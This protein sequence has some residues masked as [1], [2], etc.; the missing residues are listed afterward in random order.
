MIGI[1][2]RKRSLP[3]DIY[4]MI[5]E[6][7]EGNEADSQGSRDVKLNIKALG[8]HISDLLKFSYLLADV[9]THLT[10]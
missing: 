10:Q 2:F 8:D 6:K 1:V 7:E 9:L 4:K 3:G 5:G